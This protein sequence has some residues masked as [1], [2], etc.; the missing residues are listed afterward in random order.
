MYGY[1][2]HKKIYF[3]RFSPP[4][5]V[6]KAEELVATHYRHGNKASKAEAFFL[7]GM[8]R[9]MKGLVEQAHPDFPITIYYA[10]KQS[11]SNREGVVKHCMGGISRRCDQSWFYL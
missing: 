10:F 2:V 9:A 1:A 3:P 4:L 11:E 7:D 8:A 5:A 6:P